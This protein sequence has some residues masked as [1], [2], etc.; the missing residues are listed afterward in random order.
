MSFKPTNPDFSQEVRDRV[1]AALNQRIRYGPLSGWKRFKAWWSKAPRPSVV[2]NWGA[3]MFC[4]WVDFAA[5]LEMLFR[6]L[7]IKSSFLPEFTDEELKQAPADHTIP[8]VEERPNF[9]VHMVLKGYNATGL[10]YGHDGGNFN[11][12]WDAKHVEEDLQ[13]FDKFVKDTEAFVEAQCKARREEARR[14]E[15]LAAE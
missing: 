15:S 4:R 1:Q 8:S 9:Y 2:P 14:E 10:S 6:S 7:G 5:D 12:L 13:K 3:P 11:F